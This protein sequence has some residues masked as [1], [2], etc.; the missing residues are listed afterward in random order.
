MYRD[1]KALRV[2]EV[3]SRTELSTMFQ[4]CI[5]EEEA[6]AT[7]ILEVLSSGAWDNEPWNCRLLDRVVGEAS[8]KGIVEI[9]ESAI[10]LG[11]DRERAVW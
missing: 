3:L 6:L 8:W 4:R 1:V 7:R 9:I 10:E 11:S 5:S 2:W